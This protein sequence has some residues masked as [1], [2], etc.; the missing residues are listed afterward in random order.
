[1]SVTN[2]L[3]LITPVLAAIEFLTLIEWKMLGYI[4]LCKGPNIVGPYGLLQPF[5]DAIKL[6]TKEPLKPSTSTII[7]YITAPTLAFSI[8]LLLWT[9]F[10]IPN[11]LTNFN[12]GLLFILA[13][14]SL[15]VYSILWSG[16][17]SNSNYALIGTLRAITQTISYEVTLAIILLSVLLISGSF[18]LHI[19]TTT[20]EHL[21]LLL[22]SWP[23]AI[24]W[25]IS[26]LAETNPDPFDLTEG[27]REGQVLFVPWQQHS[28][29]ILLFMLGG[30][31]I[32]IEVV[33]FLGK[34][35]SEATCNL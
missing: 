30:E 4:Q 24:I 1:M 21:W 9:P 22:P 10:P 34:N 13:T 19:L 7:L 25:F 18:N 31:F 6:F 3:F 12:L 20:Q 8:T 2:L 35:E 27:A 23:L 14:S 16:W 33:G 11:P 17:A 26:T 32:Y 28:T 29:D 15:A 5:A